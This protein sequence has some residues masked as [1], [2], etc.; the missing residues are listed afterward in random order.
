MD[1]IWYWAG[2]LL[3]K[4]GVP[5]IYLILWLVLQDC[6][7]LSSNPSLHVETL[8]LSRVGL[9]CKRFKSREN[10]NLSHCASESKKRIYSE[11]FNSPASNEYATSRFATYEATGVPVP[12]TGGKIRGSAA[13][14][15]CHKLLLLCT[16]MSSIWPNG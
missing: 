7:R 3:E 10:Y 5:P 1:I 4:R 15:P 12:E 9:G 16:M 13:K 8:R 11:N 6:F 2:S 14:Q